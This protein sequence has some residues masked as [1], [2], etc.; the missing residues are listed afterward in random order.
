VPL[1]IFCYG[2]VQQVSW[3]IS[4]S[5]VV[6]GLALLRWLQ[7]GFKFRWPLVAEKH[8]EPRRFSW[9]NLSSF[10]LV[11][12]FVLAPAV[13][14][15]LVFF[16]AV[17]VSHFTDGFLALRPSGLT[18]QVRKYVRNDGKTLELVPMSHV[19][20]PEFYQKLTESF[21]TNS[22]ILMEGV[23]DTRN[24]LTN[25]ISYKRM[26]KSLGLAPQEKEFRPRRV[27]MVRA[28]VDVEEFTPNTI[29]FLNLVML[30]HA[31]G[32]SAENVIKLL[33]YSPP[34]HFEEQL[35]DDL[36]RKRNRRV[37]DEIGD[38]LSDS[39]NLI[40]PWG[41][42]HMPGI[43]REIPKFGFRLKE[44]QEFVAIRFASSGKSKKGAL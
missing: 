12:V 25:R 29:D 3:F 27:E 35:F 18:V 33:Q 32:V 30:I 39:E 43:A 28:D 13:I 17:A 7:G 24:L 11:N 23:T 38:R 1:L 26:A 22:T 41:A 40:V 20:E 8:L 42:A 36:L 4:L 19:G 34:P 44:T 31:K 15:Y 37:V 2:R 14:V 5:Q 21:A 6:F 16:A 10:V 9:L